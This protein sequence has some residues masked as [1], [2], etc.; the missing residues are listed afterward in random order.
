MAIGDLTDKQLKTFL[1]NYRR[2]GQTH[3]GKFTLAELLLE[4]NRRTKSPFPHVEVA[5]KIVELAQA[6]PDGLVT[7]KAVW[8]VFRPGQPWIGNAPRAEMAKALARVIAYCVDHGLPILSTLVV[9]AGSRG[10][11]PEAIQHIYNEAKERGVEVGL[12]PADFVRE[13]QQAARALTVA[14]LPREGD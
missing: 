10:H 8:E 12:V 7:Y 13:Q 9:R 1:A 3:G 6:S 4:E 14:S 5:R 2:S 11:A